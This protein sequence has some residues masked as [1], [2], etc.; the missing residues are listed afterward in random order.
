VA[1]STASTEADSVRAANA[2]IRNGSAELNRP[3]MK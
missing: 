3:R 1:F 2:N